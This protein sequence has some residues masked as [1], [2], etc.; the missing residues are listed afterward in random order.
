[1]ESILC[2]FLLNEFAAADHKKLIT[3]VLDFVSNQVWENEGKMEESQRSKNADHS[4]LS[5]VFNLLT[6]DGET[7]SHPQHKCF[8][9]SPSL[10]L[11]GKVA[12]DGGNVPQEA[13]ELM[14]GNKD[15]DE[16]IMAFFKAKEEM[17]KRVRGG[18]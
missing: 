1:V 18:H 17:M 2:V 14:T 8:S 11:L 4:Y 16:D 10:L 7:D 12:S 9:A 5:N 3:M 15:A 13:E 6:E